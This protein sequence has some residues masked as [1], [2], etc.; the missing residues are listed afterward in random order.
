MDWFLELLGRV[1][2][3]V[4]RT[5]RTVWPFLAIAV[6]TAAAVPV[7]VGLDRVSD[8]LRFRLLAREEGASP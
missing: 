4:L 7:Y 5:F 6:L 1:G 2:L 3:D 8:L